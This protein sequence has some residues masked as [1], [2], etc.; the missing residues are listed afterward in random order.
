MGARINLK[1]ENFVDFLGLQGIAK[2][3]RATDL[4]PGFIENFFMSV[5]YQTNNVKSLTAHKFFLD[6]F[7]NT[8]TKS[9]RCNGKKCVQ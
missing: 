4:K 2:P 8:K 6:S 9:Q 3:P 7:L 5:Q 1:L